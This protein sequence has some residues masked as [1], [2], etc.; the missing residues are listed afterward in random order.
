MTIKNYSVSDGNGDLLVAGL[1][2]DAALDA[3]QRH[4]NRLGETCLW[5]SESDDEEGTCEPQGQRYRITATRDGQDVASG[6]TL[7]SR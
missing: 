3:A 2:R 4:A 1:T 7:G 5:Y 6:E